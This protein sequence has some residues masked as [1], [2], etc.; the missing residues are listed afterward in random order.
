MPRPELPELPADATTV[1]V[2]GLA[3]VI[4]GRILVMLPFAAPLGP[5]RGRRFRVET[6]D[7]PPVTRVV[8][9]LGGRAALRPPGQAPLSEGEP[10]PMRLRALPQRGSQRVPADLDQALAKAGLGL[11]GLAE[12]TLRHL[13]SMVS[14]AHDPE[15]RATRIAAAVTATAA[16]QAAQAR[17]GGR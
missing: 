4:H 2:T 5:N 15:I 17:G 14:E 3:R 12:S 13:L 6:D 7:S 10:M 16:A 11:D 1:A 8:L 9:C